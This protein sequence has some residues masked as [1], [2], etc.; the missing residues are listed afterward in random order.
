MQVNLITSLVE[1]VNDSLKDHVP[2]VWSYSPVVSHILSNAK[3][4][5]T[6]LDMRDIGR[7]LQSKV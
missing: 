3:L 7:M 2:T 6:L 4:P 1:W 5:F